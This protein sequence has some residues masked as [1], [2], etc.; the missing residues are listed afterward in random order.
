ML[1]KTLCVNFLSTVTYNVTIDAYNRN[2]YYKMCFRRMKKIKE[3]CIN[4]KYRSGKTGFKGAPDFNKAQGSIFFR[5]PLFAYF[6]RRKRGL[7]V[8]HAANYTNQHWPRTSKSGG[9]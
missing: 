8:F 4:G 2:R 3:R 5:Y 9:S 7:C 6:Y 1:L